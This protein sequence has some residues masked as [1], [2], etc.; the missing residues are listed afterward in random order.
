VTVD[1]GLR[2]GNV[3]FKLCICLWGKEAKKKFRRFFTIS[4]SNMGAPEYET[5]LPVSTRGM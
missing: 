4:T 2:K 3:Y 5:W 1:E